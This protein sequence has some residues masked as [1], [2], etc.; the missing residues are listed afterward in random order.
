[1]TDRR[2]F[3]KGVLS[4]GLVAALPTPILV[5]ARPT[6]WADGIHDDAPGL[7]AMLAGE[8]FD[9]AS[10]AEGL[11][12]A[13]GEIRNGIFLIS[14]TIV[15]TADHFRMSGCR[16]IAMPELKGPMLEVTGNGT[17]LEDCQLTTA[18]REATWNTGPSLGLNVA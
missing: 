13:E 7:N 4:L 15:S 16:I 9:V 14:R 1:M 8:P 11:V 17:W 5:L 6:I 12:A 10:E 18:R 3:L 2:S